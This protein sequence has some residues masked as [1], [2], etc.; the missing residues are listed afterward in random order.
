MRIFCFRLVLICGHDR[1][2]ES[3]DATCRFVK[4]PGF[5]AKRKGAR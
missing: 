5:Q 4:A 3:I 2:E 1:A